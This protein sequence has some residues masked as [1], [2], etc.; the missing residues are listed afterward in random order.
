MTAAVDASG[1]SNRIRKNARHLARWARREGIQAW[2]VYDRDIPEFPY[3][4]DRYGDW[5]HVQLFDGKRELRDEEI[6]THLRA[7][8][9]A[10]AV[11]P[12]QLVLKVRRR[13]RGLSQYEKLGEHAPSFVVRERGRSFEVNLGR[14]L[15]TGLFLD[16]RDTRQLFGQRADGKRVLNL[17]AYTGSFTVYAALGGALSTLTVDLSR[18]YQDWTRR[19]LVL[20]GID[21]DQRHRLVA[22]DVLVWLE[23][24]AAMRERFDLIML[25]PPSFSNSKRMHESFDVQR[26]SWAAA[27]QNHG[28]ARAWGRPVFLYE[29]A[30]IPVG[31][32]A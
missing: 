13:Q 24:A 23:Q 32:G 15:D 3:A 18:T 11:A 5:L 20:N 12:A 16:H 17:F 29:S 19:N 9:D 14:Y 2:R 26:R 8:G 7:I 25:D 4:V 22:A 21:D 28:L 6:A 10:L 31:R 1:L 30:G 27:K